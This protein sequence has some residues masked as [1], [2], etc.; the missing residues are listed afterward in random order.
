MTKTLVERVCS[1][2]ADILGCDA[3]D[4]N[5]HT[6]Q[7]TMPAWDSIQHLNIVLALED[8]FNVQI[9][10]EDAE[11]ATNIGG[12]VGLVESKLKSRR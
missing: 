1:V 7:E 6:S 5:L 9:T 3:T 12:M 8:E 4:V 2:A 10:P 11:K